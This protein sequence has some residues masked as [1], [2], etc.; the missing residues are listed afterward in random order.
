M[1]TLVFLHAL[2]HDLSSWFFQIANFSRRF[3]CVAIDLPGHGRSP[4][5]LD[6][7]TVADMAAA[8]W[9][10]VDAATGGGAVA[11]VGLSAGG[12]VAKHMTISRPASVRALVLTGAGFYSGAKPYAAERNADYRARGNAYRAEHFARGF[13]AAFRATPLFAYVVGLALE[14]DDYAGSVVR[15]L[16]AIGAPEPADLHERIRVPTLVLTGTEDRSRAEQEELVR[17]V[18]ARSSISS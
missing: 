7:L 1:A 11:L 17:R 13:S 16:E 9:D 18:T 4:V 5:P 12:V 2:P 6:G 8:C 14:R 15:V 3:R 10:A